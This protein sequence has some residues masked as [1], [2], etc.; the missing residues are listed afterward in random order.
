MSD[1][2]RALPSVGVLLESDALRPLLDGFPR[3]LV[4]ETLRG[5]IDAARR[6]PREAPDSPAAWADRVRADIMQRERRLLGPVFNATGVILHTNLGRA[7]LADVAVAAIARI[8]AG[9]ATLEYDVER[10]A[11][12]SRHVHCGELL[13]E[14]TGAEDALVVNNCAAALVLALNTLADGR[15]AIVSRGELI[16]IGGS[17]RVPAIMAKSGAVLVEVGTTNRTHL[18]DY[19]SAMSAGTGAI[20]KVHRSNF[21]IDGYTAEV[22]L[23]ELAALASRRN[24]PLLHDFGSGLVLPLDDY[25]LHGEPTA[26]AVAKT[27]ATIV[28]SG[29][30]LLGG[31]Q[32]GIILGARDVIARIRD[33]P[34]MRALRVDKLT[35]AALQATLALYR[36]P[37]HAIS[38]IPVLSMIAAPIA[39]LRLRAERIVAGLGVGGISAAVID[40]E[41]S[42]GG[43]AFPT[44]RI[45]SVA[46]AVNGDAAALEAAARNASTPVIGRIANGRF[47]LDVRTIPPRDEPPLIAVML[48]ALTNPSR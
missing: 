8:A 26:A 34:L 17:F 41:A 3:A 38:A 19:E 23:D 20:V 5:A 24:V 27:G 30:K 42:V 33:N 37:V 10:G 31:P 16:E 46:V 39:A 25:G 45:P 7:P 18:T 1:P 36:D 44:A 14:L 48:R 6:E 28:M 11:R 22:S 9:Y 29:D 21:V 32:A 12:G 4:A 47:L 2:R 13:R 35:L 40:S 43:G 15:E